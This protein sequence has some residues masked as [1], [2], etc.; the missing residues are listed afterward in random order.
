MRKRQTYKFAL[1]TTILLVSSIFFNCSNEGDI[2]L[3]L[4]QSPTKKPSFTSNPVSQCTTCEI[5]GLDYATPDSYGRYSYT[6]NREITSTVIWSIINE[7]PKGSATII[8]IAETTAEIYFSK[9]FSSCLLSGYNVGQ[10]EVIL[11]IGLDH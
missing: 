10:C 4:K 11:K 5:T 6:L 2:L 7:Q 9:D 3:N 8:S 1:A